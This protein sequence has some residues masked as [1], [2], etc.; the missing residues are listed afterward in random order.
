MEPKQSIMRGQGSHSNKSVLVITNPAAGQRQQKKLAAVVSILRDRDCAVSIW[1]TSARGDAEGLARKINPDQFDVV[2]IASGDGTINEVLNGIDANAPP[3]A[4]I[5]I[6]TANVLAAEIGLEAMPKAIADTITFGCSQRINLGIAN[7]R[8]F[9]MMASMGFDAEV[10]HNVNLNL[11]HHFGKG[12]YALEALRQLFTFRAPIFELSIDGEA[13]DARSV[14]I[15]NGRYFGGRFIV[16]PDAQLKQPGFDVCRYTRSGCAATVQYMASM[17]RGSLPTRHD[18]EITR[19][20]NIH[21]SGPIG[22]PVQADGDV[23]THLPATI[24]TL[25]NAVE[26]MFPRSPEHS[27]QGG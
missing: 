19:G 1:A 3:V 13:Y 18:Y 5:P 25:P 11:K 17:A 2:A 26:L 24:S 27:H 20:A 22:A 6:G 15:A 14:I 16:A 12:A 7:G 9:A 10:V 8:R 21:I 4:I 23:I